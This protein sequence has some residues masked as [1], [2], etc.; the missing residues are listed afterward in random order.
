MDDRRFDALTR[1]VASGVRRRSFLLGVVAATLGARAEFLG[2]SRDAGAEVRGKDERR[3]PGKGG[4][5]RDRAGNGSGAKGKVGVC[6]RTNSATNPFVYI[7]VSPNAV[8]AHAAHGDA[9]GVDLQTDP[10]NCGACGNACGGGNACTT[11]ACRNGECALDPVDCDDGNACTLDTCDP[12][13][14]CRH[15]PVNC[16]D[17]DACTIDAC[18]PARG[19]THT[20][21]DCNDGNA[22]TTDSCDSV[23]GCLHAPVDCSDGNACTIDSCDP[24]RG[25]LH[26]PVNCDDQNECTADTCDPVRGC[27]HTPRTDAP[28]AGGTGV[29]D[30]DGQCQPKVACPSCA[31]NEHCCPT[32]GNCV[33]CDDGTVF[34]PATCGCRRP[35]ACNDCPLSD[36]SGMRRPCGD[37]GL[38][39]CWV[40]SDRASCFCG[41]FDLCSNHQ[42]C[43][44]GDSCPAGQT[45]IVNGCNVGPGQ[46]SKLC[47][48]AC[49]SAAATD[50]RGPF[51][52]RGLRD[53]ARPR[54]RRRRR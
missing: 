12:A 5:R 54:R 44:P 29:C 38:C 6:H 46:L 27:I 17:G 15:A 3:A 41:P 8:A 7:E 43:G 48:P 11:P 2:S 39:Q 49:T 25:C 10:A 26:T 40:R 18:D 20:A 52:K 16:D 36:P 37:G 30:K 24:V 32:T 31:P 51:G 50:A 28:C 4:R 47:Y 33:A 53:D 45:C 42:P 22:C 9:T 14:G 23:R 35:V 34:D 19:C 21:R 13:D 1:L